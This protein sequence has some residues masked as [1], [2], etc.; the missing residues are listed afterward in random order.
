MPIPISKVN[1]RDEFREGQF[2]PAELTNLLPLLQLHPMIL[3]QDTG[4]N[5][6]EKEAVKQVWL[7]SSDLGE[8]RIEITPGVLNQHLGLL[9]SKGFI[10]GEGNVYEFTTSGRKL[11]K[12]S[13]LD[14]EE[15]AFSKQASKQLVAKNSYDFGKDVL[16]KVNHPEKFGTKY[17]T[18]PKKAFA[19]KN[20]KAKE[21]DEYK[22]A[23]KDESGE[24]RRLSSYTDEELVTVLHLAKNVINNASRIAITSGKSVPIHRIKAFAEMVMTELNKERGDK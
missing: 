22:V 5:K 21:I 6:A 7:N 13:I 11:L 14:D 23:T 19:K 8:D 1:E 2:D 17:I 3:F 9:E 24:Y 12:E 16:I 18:I 4:A 10:R 15:S 20:M